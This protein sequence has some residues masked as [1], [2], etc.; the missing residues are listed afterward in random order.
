[1]HEDLVKIRLRMTPRRAAIRYIRWLHSIQGKHVPSPRGQLHK[2]LTEELKKRIP[3][4]N[5]LYRLLIRAHREFCF[6]VEVYTVTVC[7]LI[8]TLN[9]SFQLNSFVLAYCDFEDEAPPELLS[10]L[11]H[12][13]NQISIRLGAIDEIQEYFI[14]SSVLPTYIRNVAAEQ[15][16]AMKDALESVSS[17]GHCGTSLL[18][19][20]ST[21]F[22]ESRKHLY[23]LGQQSWSLAAP[24]SSFDK[25]VLMLH[26]AETRMMRG[27]ADYTECTR[28]LLERA[29]RDQIPDS[30]LPDQDGAADRLNDN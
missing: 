9:S 20:P 25:A 6:F 7:S 28:H 24:Y 14:G 11:A 15:Q 8:T 27:F 23:K 18:L 21:C 26:E 5:R 1:M 2:E 19:D 3:E 12:L 29:R 16:A 10:R 22:K 4:S 17:D 30:S 13:H